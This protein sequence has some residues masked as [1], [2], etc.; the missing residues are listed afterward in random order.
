MTEKII[1]G[2]LSA[3]NRRFAVVGARWNGMFSEP[4]IQGAIDALRRHG[5]DDDSITVVRVPGSFE[6][7]L[8][9]AELARSG[10][11]DAIIT[12][13]T[14]IRGETDHYDLIARELSSGLSRV[15]FETGVPVAF[16]V[17]TANSM[18]Q[19]MARAGGKAG[20]KGFEAALAAIEMANVLA[21]IHLMGIKAG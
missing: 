13:G 18:E 1:Q 12:V 21:E 14:L 2:E 5:A 7:P 19:A 8:A 20:N 9:A 15:M 10:R 3:A 6:I 17:V 16:G 11:F 4:L